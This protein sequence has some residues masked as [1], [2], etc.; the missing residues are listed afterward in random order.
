M[1]R[2]TPYVC[3]L[4]LSAAVT[5]ASAATVRG[6]ATFAGQPISSVFPSFSHGLA[7]AFDTASNT[8]TLGTADPADGT[9]E[10]NGVGDGSTYVRV[11]FGPQD[12]DGRLTVK[13]GELSHG[14]Y[15]EVAGGGDVV[16][17][18]E[19]RYGYRITQPFDGQWPG[20]IDICP[21]GAELASEFTFSWEPVPL[22]V[23]YR[24]VV[25]HRTCSGVSEIS[26]IDTETTSVRI[27]QG[28]VAQEDY[29]VI[30]LEAITVGDQQV[31]IRPYIDYQNG[32]SDGAFVYLEEEEGRSP[33][34]PSSVF[35]SQVANL[36]GVPPS[37]WTSDVVLTNPL[38]ASVD[39]TL[40]FTP[41]GVDGLTDYL[42]ATVTVPAH[43][44]RVLTDVVGS[45]FS[46]T[47]AGSLEVSPAALLVSSRISTPGP[48][49]GSYGQGFPA[50]GTNDSASLAGTVTT[51]GVGGL[52]RG[53]FRSNLVLTEVW[54]E[55]VNVMVKVFDRDG[56]VLGSTTAGLLPFGTTQ[57]NDVVGLVGGPSILT[58]GQLTVEVTSGQG[59]VVAVL[60]MVD[61]VTQ[62]PTTVLLEPR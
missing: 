23:R 41:R 45:V 28:T 22:A 13:A 37:F 55:S 48:N 19:A 47:G 1:P 57:I 5:A 36:P 3:A 25:Q 10:I 30:W 16:F 62:D 39:A 40:Y 43:A 9:Y 49:G 29:L 7:A 12:F 44:C 58:E 11:L 8:W 56:L 42:T 38:S 26:A 2:S 51:L 18:L 54:G 32:Y 24:V 17:D 60:S 14:D 6:T 34:P 50:S 46:T 33:H 20:R 31:A 52:A 21:P 53:D 35:V 4:I 27:S 59:R 61:A 15:V